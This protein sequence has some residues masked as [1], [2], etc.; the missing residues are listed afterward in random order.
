MWARS[1]FGGH[2]HT[3]YAVAVR[4]CAGVFEW[5]AHTHS[6]A[7]G[8]SVRVDEW[9]GMESAAAQFVVVVVPGIGGSSEQQYVRAL[10]KEC[11][12]VRGWRVA[13]FNHRGCGSQALTSPHLFTFGDVD[14]LNVAVRELARRH[15]RAKFG[16]VGC[17]FVPTTMMRGRTL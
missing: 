11:G 16:M 9:V 14:D 5:R 3:A 12:E 4:R 7:H 13:V 17:R 2:I 15:P 6:V 8:G 1:P 10:V